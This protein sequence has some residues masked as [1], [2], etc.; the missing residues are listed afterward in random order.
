MLVV[1]W[2]ILV[3]CVGRLVELVFCCGEVNGV[4]VCVVVE[5][6]V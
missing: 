3:F 2:L 5:V 1:V 6:V 4:K